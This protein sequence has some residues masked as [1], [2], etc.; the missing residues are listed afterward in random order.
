MAS[1]QRRG[2]ISDIRPCRRAD[3]AGRLARTALPL[4]LALSACLGGCGPSAREGGFDSDN[5][6]ARLYAIQHAAEQPSPHALRHLVSS[7]EHDD[8]AVRVWAIQAIER[9]TGTRL[10]YNPYADRLSRRRAVE[11]WIQATRE[12]RFVSPDRSPGKPDSSGSSS[13]ASPRPSQDADD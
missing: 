1:M 6:A 10:G 11:R 13:A 9:L 5:P 12:G 4:G 3:G 8:P 7:L 2:R